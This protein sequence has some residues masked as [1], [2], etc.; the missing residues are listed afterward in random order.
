MH[1]YIYIYVNRYKGYI[2][3]NSSYEIATLWQFNI[4]VEN[5]HFQ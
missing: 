4:A 2:R 3:M 5:R 1:M